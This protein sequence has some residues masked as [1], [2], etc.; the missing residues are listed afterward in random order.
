MSDNEVRKM[1]KRYTGLTPRETATR[2]QE[3]YQRRR[4][5]VERFTD[6]LEQEGLVDDGMM[7]SLR[8]MGVTE[9]EIVGLIERYGK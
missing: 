1:T 3:R 5:A 2:L 4:D 7:L 8:A 6:V 9:A